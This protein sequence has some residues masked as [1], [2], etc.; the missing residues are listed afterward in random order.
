VTVASAVPV[1]VAGAAASVA[2]LVAGG[3]VVTGAMV[4]V[5]VACAACPP[6]ADKTIPVS[7]MIAS[8][9]FDMLD[10]LVQAHH[11]RMGKQI[12][13]DFPRYVHRVSRSIIQ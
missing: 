5:S 12:I 10:S 9:F 2:V 8:I 1:S 13:D 3:A 6:Q 7:K 11:W 4:G